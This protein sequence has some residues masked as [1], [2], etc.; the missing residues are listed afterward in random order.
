MDF[1]ECGSLKLRDK[2]TNRNCPVK[3]TKRKLW[4]IEGEPLVFSKPV[5]FEYASKAGNRIKLLKDEIRKEL[6]VHQ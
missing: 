1:C 2:C 6:T 3:G 4:L 5:T